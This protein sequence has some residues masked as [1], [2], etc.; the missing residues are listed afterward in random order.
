MANDQTIATP[1]ARL[2]SGSLTEKRATDY[3][4]KPIAEDNQ[5]YQYG[6][7]IRKDDPGINACLQSVM[8]TVWSDFAQSPQ[9]QAIISQFNLAKNSGFSWKIKDGDTPNNDGKINPN[10]KGCYVIYFSTSYMTK[11]CDQNNRELDANN[12]YCGCFVQV[13]FTAVGNGKTDNTAGAYMNPQV[14]RFIAHGEKIVGGI[15]A[16]TAFAG[17]AVPTLLPPGASLTPVATGGMPGVPQTGT[18]P[19][20]GQPISQ[21]GL[22]TV[23]PTTQQN[24]PSMTGYPT[25]DLN[26]PWAPMAQ[27]AAPETPFIPRATQPPTQPGM[28]PAAQAAPIP[29]F[30][31]GQA[32][33]PVAPTVPGLPQA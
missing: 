24:T 5:R 21:Q 14:V 33:A 28:P 7:A 30:H 13:A 22:P 20:T 29:N 10:T 19:E 15:D 1:V 4:G 31:N 3:Q 18:S 23:H 27:Q 16:E 17:V 25:N 12:F 2:V 6:V 9:T 26:A 8:Q 11:T 32:T